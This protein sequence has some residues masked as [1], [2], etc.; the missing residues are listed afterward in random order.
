MTN[1]FDTVITASS[2][3]KED[4]QILMS[5]TT[6]TYWYPLLYNPEESMSGVERQSCVESYVLEGGPESPFETL[7]LQLSMKKLKTQYPSLVNNIEE[8]MNKII[9]NAVGRSNLTVVKIKV[10]DTK[11][12][13]TAYSD[14]EVL[15]GSKLA[16]TGTLQPYEW[17]KEILTSGTYGIQYVEDSTLFISSS[18]SLNSDKL[19]DLLYFSEGESVWYVLQICALYMNCKIFFCD[20]KV[21]VVDFTQPFGGMADGILF[22]YDVLNLRPESTQN[23]MY[24]RTTGDV[25]IGD[26]GTDTVINYIDARCTDELGVMKTSVVVTTGND[27]GSVSRYGMRAGNT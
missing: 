3:Y 22:D 12:T 24:G 7:T 14:A 21:Y 15:R 1:N 11:M 13:L 26:E 27:E 5:D 16:M 23:V 10:R 20:N 9:L 18:F 17:I 6:Q 25:E 19:S 4:F 2:I 8:G